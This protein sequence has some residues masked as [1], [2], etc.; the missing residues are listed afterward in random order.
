MTNNNM[1][2]FPYISK[3][4]MR[5]Y[6]KQKDLYARRLHMIANI[7]QNK[8]ITNPCV[9]SLID[10]DG[11]IV[12]E[13]YHRIYGGPH[14]EVN[15]IRRKNLDPSLSS[16]DNLDL[17]V[18]LE[19]CNHNGKTPPC[20]DLII[21]NKFN[22][23]YTTRI[24]PNPLMQGKSIEYLNQHHIKTTVISFAK[25]RHEIRFEKNITEGLPYV[26][27]KFAHSSDGFL[28]KNGSP[29]QIS[30]QL[31]SV[32]VHKWRSECDGILIGK[33]TLVR[34]NPKL[35]VRNYFGKDPLRIILSSDPIPDIKRYN[36][37]QDDNFIN[38]TTPDNKSSEISHAGSLLN[39]LQEL[40]QDFNIG[41]IFVEGGTK[42][43][44][45]FI[46]QDL[47][48]EIRTIE[49]T[50]LKLESGT[51]VPELKNAYLAEEKR[52][53]NDMVR[54]FYNPKYV[55]KKN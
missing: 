35:T 34:D 42:T 15:T 26:I 46:D 23:C 10:I 28:D 54:L 25:R 33:N 55:L 40:Y 48:D 16:R 3:I 29:V 44:Q 4:R 13:D 14:A 21:K 37:A 32:L 20:T 30:N 9:A 5:K 17:Y 22:N 51:E 50:T 27:L 41:S 39:Q 49:N 2:T 45:H 8:V 47:W 12:C 24:D 43:L 36:V 31:S 11:T 52:L 38:L 1:A 18:S 7:C 53:R 19:P 6:K